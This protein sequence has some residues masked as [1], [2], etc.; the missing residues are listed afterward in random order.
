MVHPKLGGKIK[1]DV[2]NNNSSIRKAQNVVPRDSSKCIH[3]HTH[4]GTH[5]HEHS[6]YT[7]LNLHSLKMGSKQR[8]ELDEDSSTEQ[9]TWQV[10]SFGKINVFR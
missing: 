6:D 1:L 8:L 10:Y 4:R 7:K 5:T 9:K 2:H 3:T